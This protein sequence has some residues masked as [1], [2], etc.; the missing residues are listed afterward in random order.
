MAIYSTRPDVRCIIHIHTPATAAVSLLPPS[1]KSKKKNQQVNLMNL[2]HLSEAESLL[3]AVL[4][5][6][7]TQLHVVV[8]LFK[9]K[10]CCE[11]REGGAIAMK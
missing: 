9:I 3:V 4:V 6:F 1:L 11:I 8:F 5:L 2:D 10:L 7:V